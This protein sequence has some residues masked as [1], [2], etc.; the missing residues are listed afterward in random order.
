[1]VPF[2]LGSSFSPPVSN[3]GGAGSNTPQ[4][5]T[6]PMST[7]RQNRRE[8][9]E[10]LGGGSGSGVTTSVSPSLSGWEDGELI[11]AQQSPR[12]PHSQKRAKG[13]SAKPLSH[14]RDAA[15]SRQRWGRLWPP[16]PQ[17]LQALA[18]SLLLFF[19]P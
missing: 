11:L 12:T 16:P 6:A 1:M 18:L 3:L 10:H 19:Q 15:S 17:G 9:K 4:P 2:K 5:G 8:E 7:L 13:S 14:C